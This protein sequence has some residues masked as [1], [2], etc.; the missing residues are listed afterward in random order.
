MSAQS[1]HQHQLLPGATSEDL[2]DSYLTVAGVEA[3]PADG[4]D[5]VERAT[6]DEALDQLAAADRSVADLLGG[7]ATT[8]F[9]V[10]CG[11]RGTHVEASVFVVDGST[12]SGEG[13]LAEALPAAVP[14]RGTALVVVGD[15]PG[16]AARLTV[17]SD[18]SAHLAP[19][20]LDFE[21]SGLPSETSDLLCHLLESEVDEDVEE[22]GM[23][24]DAGP[25]VLV[26][27]VA[28]PG[29][30]PGRRRP[31]R[32]G[33][34]PAVDALRLRAHGPRRQRCAGAGGTTRRPRPAV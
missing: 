9:A 15:A 28:A 18:G 29:R 8:T 17:S 7:D 19:L 31:G 11:A 12:S 24:D 22:N 10:R 2:A 4:L 16:A 13:R 14:H 27:P 6:V 30:R 1:T 33:R 25:S 32:A 23:E 34:I 5:R 21:A 3:G 26:E 20:G